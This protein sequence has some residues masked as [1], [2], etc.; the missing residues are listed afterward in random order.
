LQLREE[1]AQL[2]PLDPAAKLLFIRQ[3]EHK[4]IKVASR[5]RDFRKAQRAAQRKRNARVQQ[6]EDMRKQQEVLM[7]QLKAEQRT[8]DS[9][10]A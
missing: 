10:S 4:R 3:A 1:T 2:I 7:Q 8:D 6:V 9:F 5:T